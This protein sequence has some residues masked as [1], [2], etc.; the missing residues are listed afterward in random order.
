MPLRVPMFAD[1]GKLKP[2]DLAAVYGN[3][4]QDGAK[5]EF[6][7]T[8]VGAV[9]FGSFAFIW[10]DV[11]ILP[12]RNAAVFSEEIS[13]IPREMTEPK[14]FITPGEH[15]GC[16][17]LRIFLVV[18]YMTRTPTGIEQFPLPIIYTDRIPSVYAILC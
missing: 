12:C 4:L 2:D 15:P 11:I 1:L 8:L 7:E 13:L 18:A 17:L 16:E 9:E 6:G 14:P 10:P 3:V 5:R